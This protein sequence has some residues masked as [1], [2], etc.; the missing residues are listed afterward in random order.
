MKS[1]TL[2]KQM[3]MT[4]LEVLIATGILT[5][6]SAMAFLSIDNMVRSKTILN[7]QTEQLN[8]TNLAF[9]LLQNDLQFAISSQQLGVAEAEFV[10]GIQ[11]FTLTR[12]KRQIATSP[13]VEDH[14][15]A[16]NQPLQKV[17][18]YIRDQQLERAVLP[19]H[20][21][22]YGE[23]WQTRTLL[24]I[25]SFNCSYQNAAGVSSNQWPNEGGENGMLP[26][27]IQCLVVTESGQANEFNV[28]PWEKIW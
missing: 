19:A 12:F 2:I 23:N 22:G 11:S 10:G 24:P 5:V 16:I 3:G 7:Q 8:Q 6:I 17:R 21:T 4:L 13:R 14:N 27:S 18:W 9:Y 28:V 15:A 20:S 25:E 1:P 26:N